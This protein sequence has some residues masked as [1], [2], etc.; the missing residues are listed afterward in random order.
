MGEQRK[1]RPYRTLVLLLSAVVIIMLC[2]FV[3]WVVYGLR[4]IHCEPGWRDIYNQ[5]MTSSYGTNDRADTLIAAT[6][7]A[8][9]TRKAP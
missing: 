5:T 7:A 2:M 6:Q 3:L 1:M 8:K 9:V 4:C